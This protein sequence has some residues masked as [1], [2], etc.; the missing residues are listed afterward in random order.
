MKQGQF[1]AVLSLRN[2]GNESLACPLLKG[3]S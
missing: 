1:P 2:L 3:N